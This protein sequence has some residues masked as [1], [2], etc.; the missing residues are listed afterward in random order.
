MRA[1]VV[2]LAASCAAVGRA[3]AACESAM[4][5]SLNGDCA[6]GSCVCDAGWTGDACGT[7][8]FL[9]TPPS[10]G[11]FN[12]SASSWGGYP[13]RDP[14]SGNWH[15]FAA[16]MVNGCGLG[17]WKT[18][19]RVIRA[20]SSSGPL[21]PFSFAE[22]V[23]APFAHNPA[24]RV[25]PVTGEVLLFFIGG[26]TRTPKV[27]GSGDEGGPATG[28]ASG[29][30]WAP[31]CGPP[32]LNDGCGIHLMTAP[33][34]LG[35]WAEA[36]A[37]YVNVTGADWA[38]ARTNPG[39]WA[40]P[41]GTVMLALNAGYCHAH[42]EQIGLAWAKRGVAGGFS[43]RETGPA[44][45]GGHRDE[46]PF[47]WRSGRGWHMLVHGLEQGEPEGRLAF[48]EDGLSWRLGAAPAYNSTI[49]FTNGTTVTAAT[50]QRPQLL[51]APGTE[52][53]AAPRPL[54]LWN[55]A[56]FGAGMWGESHTLV[57]PVNTAEGRAAARE[58]LSAGRDRT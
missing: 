45:A 58:C 1:W 55:G 47:L 19:S 50:V 44:I 2:V 48:S 23:H 35:P 42:D 13:V 14:S 10:A 56:S 8:D 16:E 18:N 43:M 27:C 37:R 3:A 4:D 24:P 31:D 22:Q 41:N 52:H 51:F 28:P 11:Y 29:L 25:D 21:G 12:A 26:W 9:P 49:V 30:G 54:A 6:S 38:C 5:C 15:L 34:A 40:L 39:A 53:S 17:D 32:P 33:S 36:S 7:L 46:D 20:E 57:R